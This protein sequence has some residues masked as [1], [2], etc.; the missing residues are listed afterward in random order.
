MADKCLNCELP[1][2]LLDTAGDCHIIAGELSRELS[3]PRAVVVEELARFIR[4]PLGAKARN[5]A[6]QMAYQM[7]NPERGAALS[8]MKARRDR[9][10]I[11]FR[12][13]E[14]CKNNR[15]QLR[16]NANTRYRDDVEYRERKKQRARAYKEKHRAEINERR[17]HKLAA[18]PAFREKPREQQRA[19]WRANP[20]YRAK[21][22]AASR[23]SKANLS[24]EKKAARKA[25]RNEH[26]RQRYAED[27]AHRQRLR[28]SYL[29]RFKE[30]YHSDARFRQRHLAQGKAWATNKKHNS[31][32]KA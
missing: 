31:A 1:E 32:S 19:H 18:D 4:S 21:V 29:R 23:R 13:R 27:A 24:A 26:R 28:D 8:R 20:A 17:R 14:Y 22:N 9:I 16:Q 6:R 30:R 10:K 5:A 7:R 11:L 25:R 2:C 3:K 15:E 12:Y